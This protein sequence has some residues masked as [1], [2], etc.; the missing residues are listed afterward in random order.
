[1]NNH[2]IRLFDVDQDRL[3]NIMEDLPHLAGWYSI[4]KNIFETIL[5]ISAS[6]SFS[7]EDLS[8][9]L[10]CFRQNLISSDG[11]TLYQL[12]A[13]Y[14]DVFGKSIILFDQG[15]LGFLTS[16]ILINLENK[17]LLK[18]SY[19]SADLQEIQKM[20]DFTNDDISML[21]YAS[22]KS[23][24]KITER[25]LETNVSDFLVVS[26]TSFNEPQNLEY[27]LFQPRGKNVTMVSDQNHTDIQSLVLTGSS[28]DISEAVAQQI[29]WKLIHKLKFGQ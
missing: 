27:R 2:E 10:S 6:E 5:R 28:A 18:R 12:L 25:I 8:E 14:L 17:K 7:N 19:I 1:M 16:Q 29:A 4:E 15:T 9:V 13:S 26:L 24:Y 22:D 11:R 23:A 20:F 3:H 21:S